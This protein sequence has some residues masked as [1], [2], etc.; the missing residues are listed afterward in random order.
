MAILLG[1]SLIASLSISKGFGGAWGMKL[2]AFTGFM[3][4]A[5]A[6]MKLVDLRRFAT[7]F[8]MFDLLGRRWTPWC[9]AYPFCE[10]LLGE[11]YFTYVAPVTIYSV[12]LGLGLFNALGVLTAVRG[13]LDRTDMRLANPLKMP[14]CF[15]MMIESV[16]MIIM[17]GLLLYL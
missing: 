12:T 6:L 2:Q 9:Y 13:G 14:L 10:L 8:G 1:A 5:F 15:V 16:V 7:G 4:C 3:L 17:A 11:A